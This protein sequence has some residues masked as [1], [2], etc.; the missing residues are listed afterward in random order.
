MVSVDKFLFTVLHQSKPP[1]VSLHLAICTAILLA[2]N[3]EDMNNR[4]GIMNSLVVTSSMIKKDQPNYEAVHNCNYYFFLIS[5]CLKV[6]LN[7]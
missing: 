1:D 3:F 4:I 7:P 2:N 5:F 6:N